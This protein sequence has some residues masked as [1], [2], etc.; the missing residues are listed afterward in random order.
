MDKRTLITFNHLTLGRSL[1][2][3]EREHHIA[4]GSLS[5]FAKRNGLIVR[6]KQE[7]AMVD[8]SS[9]RRTAPAGATHWAWGHTKETHPKYA[10]HSRRMTE[11]N[12]SHMPGVTER[13]LETKVRTGFNEKIRNRMIG[14]EISIE[15]REKIAQS[16]APILLENMRRREQMM[17]DALIAFDD[18]WICQYQFGAAVLDFAITDFRVAFEIDV[19]SHKLQRSLARDL[20]LVEQGWTILR[21]RVENAAHPHYFGH[22]FRIAEQLIPDF[23]CPDEYPLPRR[24][25]YRVVIRCPEYPT[26][27]SVNYPNDVILQR[28]AATRRYGLPSPIVS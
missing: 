13:A 7:Q 16:L 14:R 9:G 10:E 1:R 18:R 27:L 2:S 17:R 21:F 23:K 24:K 5:L 6:T 22:A 25:P 8:F 28:L 11:Q 20:R 4:N 3:L 12:P 26:G 19:G 15:T